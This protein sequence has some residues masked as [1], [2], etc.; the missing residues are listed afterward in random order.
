MAATIAKP[1]QELR[2]VLGVRPPDEI[3]KWLNIFIYGD[4]GVGKTF[5]AGT[6]DDDPRTSPVLFLDVEGGVTTIKERK[7]VDVK[8]IR[9]MK[10]IELVGTKLAA[11]IKDDSI[12]YR[13][14]VI[15]SLTE[16]ADL[17]MR[18]EMKIAL[19]KNPD[20]VNVDVPSPREWG[21][22]RNHIR[23]ITRHFKDLPCHVVFTGHLGIEYNDDGRPKQYHPAFAGKLAREIPGFVDVI[24]YYSQKVRG[25]EVV[26]T[27]QTQGTDRVI[28]KDRTKVLGPLITDPT[29]PMLWDMVLAS[30]K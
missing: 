3:V 15:D 30:Q 29:I 25:E 20:T 1:D 9:S 12:Y 16:L 22:V 5:L 6:A 21:I 11:S 19:S 14:I 2:A 26:R 27:L 8:S 7:N 28:A 23:I 17:D 24:G 18:A 4:S 13:T 10:D